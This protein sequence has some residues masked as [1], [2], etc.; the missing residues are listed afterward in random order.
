MK[1]FE[2]ETSDRLT[3]EERE[4]IESLLRYPSLERVFDQNQPH[5]LADTKKKMQSNIAGLER[6]IRGGAK[7]DA[8]RAAKIVA[9]YQTTINF[10]DELEQMRNNQAK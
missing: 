10:L 3:D 9:A 4:T 5:N 2:A 1:R 7:T 8:E 6:T